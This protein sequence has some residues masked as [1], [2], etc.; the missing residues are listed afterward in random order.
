MQYMLV[1]QNYRD[2]GFNTPNLGY[3]VRTCTL[4][5]HHNDNETDNALCPSKNWKCWT[6]FVNDRTIHKR[7]QICL[8][9]ALRFV[10]I[11]LYLT[12]RPP[13]KNYS[14]D[15]YLYMYIY[16]NNIYIQSAP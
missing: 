12:Y 14:I 3:N 1:C 16:N 13:F 8:F 15:S 9:L 11:F 6:K 10:N 5:I 7:K 4:Y 2:Q